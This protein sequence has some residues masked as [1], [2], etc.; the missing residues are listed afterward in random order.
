MKISK[1]PKNPGGTEH[2]QT[3]SYFSPHTQEPGNE[4]MVV[5][6]LRVWNLVAGR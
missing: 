1:I 3:G 5:F 4:A 6:K 2:V